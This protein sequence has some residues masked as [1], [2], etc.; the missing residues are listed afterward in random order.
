M[1]RP[2][3]QMFSLLR[4]NSAPPLL[5]LQ[6]GSNSVQ[7]YSA[8]EWSTVDLHQDRAQSFIDDLLLPVIG[9]DSGLSA[10]TDPKR[11]SKE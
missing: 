7:F 9:P 8:G 6:A 1:G 3:E 2:S 10:K 5:V 11:D 4:R